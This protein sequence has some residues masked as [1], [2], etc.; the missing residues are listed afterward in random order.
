MP[1]MEVDP[2]EAV[3]RNTRLLLANAERARVAGVICLV[4]GK[5][6]MVHVNLTAL[7]EGMPDPHHLE[8][9]REGICAFDVL[10][11]RGELEDLLAGL[12]TKAVVLPQSCRVATIPGTTHSMGPRYLTRRFARQNWHIDWPC[13]EL[14]LQGGGYECDDLSDRFS[15]FVEALPT[16]DPPVAGRLALCSELG[17]VSD[18]DVT[19]GGGQ[20]CVRRPLPARLHSI[21]NTE[22]VNEFDITVEA[23]GPAA[24][25]FSVSVMPDTGRRSALRLHARDFELV[26]GSASL[27]KKRV[28]LSEPGSVKVSLSVRDG[29]AADEMEAGLPW[30]PMLIHE[31]LD[32]GCELL[33]S[34][35][36]GPSGRGQTE[37]R[38][39]ERGVTWL[40]HLCGCAA[41][42]LGRSKREKDLQGSSD[43]VGTT[44]AGDCLIGEC[45]LKGPSDDKLGKLL[46]RAGSIRRMLQRAGAPRDVR[47]VFFVGEDFDERFQGVE[48]VDLA[49]LRRMFDRLR[50]GRPDGL[51]W[52]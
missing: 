2:R 25:A 47:V 32:P 36:F 10:L 1:E 15:R 50:T 14:T 19:R 8:L 31:Q 6:L 49:R 7:H 34:L 41:M 22:G 35:L 51:C 18:L 21:D 52:S 45:S 46:E 43:I 20:M 11:D 38:E 37:S 4:R 17:L 13:D 5:W 29:E 40:L 30:V 39:F 9:E 42:H 48:F 12:E 3:V 33:Q 16:M 27:W 28:R 26:T 24:G 23:H 44:P